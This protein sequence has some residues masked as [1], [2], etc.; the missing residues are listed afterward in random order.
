MEQRSRAYDDEW[1]LSI[2]P[3]QSV[4]VAHAKASCATRQGSARERQAY[5]RTGSGA[6]SCHKRQRPASSS[7]CARGRPISRR[8]AFMCP[9]RVRGRAGVP[10]HGSHPDSCRG[11]LARLMSYRRVLHISA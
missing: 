5:T 9:G 10:R 7:R 1:G 8:S 11:V 2:V 6:Y 3:V 4:F